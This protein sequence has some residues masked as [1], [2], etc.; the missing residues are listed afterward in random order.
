MALKTVFTL[1]DVGRPLSC[2]DTGNMDGISG[3]RA[4]AVKI[5]DKPSV[6]GSISEVSFHHIEFAL[7]AVLPFIKLNSLAFYCLEF[8][9]MRPIS[10]NISNN[11]GIP[12]INDG[13][14]DEES[15]GRGRVKD[16]EVVIFDPW[17]IEVGSRVCMC[18]KGDGILRVTVL[19]SPYDVSIDTN[20]SESDILCHLILTILVEE[21]KWVLPRITAVILTLSSS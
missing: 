7:S 11:A 4:N 1:F 20:L 8:T 16:I 13:I 2:K 6:D 12:E 9:L 18:M 21:N 17:T 10:I 14:V 5:R 19:A 15:G 3:R